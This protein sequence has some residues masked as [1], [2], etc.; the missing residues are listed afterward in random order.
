LPPSSSKS[1]VP[2]W[3]WGA[4]AV[5]LL[6]ALY[7]AYQ[8]RQLRNEIERIR[9]AEAAQAK[10]FEQ[11]AQSL[12]SAK[13]QAIILTD[14]HSLKIRMLAARKGTPELQAVW[15]PALGIVVSGQSLRVSSDNRVLQLWLIPKATGGKPI[16]SLFSRPDGG[17]NFQLLV[18]DPPGSQSGAK[19]L[20]ITEE[21]EGGSQQPTTTQ[22]WIGIIAG[23]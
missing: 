14:S 9:A 13:R 18:A 21:P 17:G 16:P 20:A 4:G 1:T 11:S 7:N 5:V 2:F 15:H 22:I 19:A 10:E 23:R 6:F 8:A 12:D 3:M